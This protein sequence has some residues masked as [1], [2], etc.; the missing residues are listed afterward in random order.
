MLIVPAALV[1]LGLV[2][3]LVL[4]AGGGG[5]G[6]IFGGGPDDTIPA[7]D[8]RIAKAQPIVVTDK[9]PAQFD[10]SAA[11]VADDVTKTMTTLYTEAFLDPSNWRDGTYDNVWPLFDEGSRASAQQDGTTL[12]LGTSAGDTFEK[13]GR[14][15]GKITVKVLLDREEK[16]SMAVAIVK[17][18]ALG[19][20]KDGTYT[21]IV[22]TGQYFL[23]PGD[24]GW[25]VYAFQ[26]RRAD[27]ETTPPPG[28]SGSPSGASS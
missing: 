12:T 13:V 24:S 8:F 20:R 11:Q 5:A 26:V 18:T 3:F 22:S 25:T 7:F 27:H 6:G 28:P 23:K 14:P 10:S 15:K 4:R 1:A 21:E 17:F 16:P 9:D 2:L 19:T